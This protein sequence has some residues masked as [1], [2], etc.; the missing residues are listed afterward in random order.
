MHFSIVYSF[1]NLY[2]M[3][4]LSQSHQISVQYFVQKLKLWVFKILKKIKSQ[5][6]KKMFFFLGQNEFEQKK[7]SEINE[8]IPKT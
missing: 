3:S 6:L 5:Q 4:I 1:D 8:K 7:K 2:F